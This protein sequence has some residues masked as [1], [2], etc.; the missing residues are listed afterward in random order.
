IIA[1]MSIERVRGQGAA[2]SCLELVLLEHS[3]QLAQ[4]NRSLDYILF[5]R[6]DQ[7][8]R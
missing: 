7:G 4:A 2:S 1:D 8:N 3:E 5:S 6:K